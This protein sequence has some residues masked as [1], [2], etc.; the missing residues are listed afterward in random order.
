[1]EIDSIRG[2]IIATKVIVLVV[3]LFLTAEFVLIVLFIQAIILFVLVLMGTERKF[4]FRQVFSKSLTHRYTR[5][6]L[7]WQTRRVKAADIVRQSVCLHQHRQ[8]YPSILPRAAPVF[9][10]V[11]SPLAC[12]HSASTLTHF[13]PAE[14]DTSLPRL[15]TYFVSGVEFVGGSLLTVGFLSSLACAAGRNPH[16]G[17]NP[18]LSDSVEL[19]ERIHSWFLVRA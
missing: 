10:G 2:H 1:M 17:R 4:V 12:S 11:T 8:T 18:D 6:W 9:S 3:F 14:N 15:M 5:E 19:A 7:K 16:N 13:H